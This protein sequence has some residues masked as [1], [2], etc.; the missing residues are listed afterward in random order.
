MERAHQADCV[1]KIESL[2]FNIE[3][4]LEHPQYNDEYD[5][6]LLFVK[7]DRMSVKS[8]TNVKNLFPI[9]LDMYLRN[10]I[11]TLSMGNCYEEQGYFDSL[12]PV[13]N[14]DLN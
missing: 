4:A 13:N 6:P 5:Q 9:L 10:D 11:V 12:F 8:Y 7:L 3:E 1:G 14:F 2:E